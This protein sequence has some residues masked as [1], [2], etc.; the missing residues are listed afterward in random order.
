MSFS[1]AFELMKI[2]PVENDLNQTASGRFFI[3]V[4]MPGTWRISKNDRCFAM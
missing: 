2:T 4:H 1:V 3:E